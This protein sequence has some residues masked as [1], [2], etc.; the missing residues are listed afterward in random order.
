M[1]R[2]ND[3]GYALVFALVVLLFLSIVA[4]FMMQLTGRDL[5]AQIA[6]VDRM[7]AQ[8]SAQG[9]LEKIIAQIEKSSTIDQLNTLC[10]GINSRYDVNGG[11]NTQQTPVS[12]AVEYQMT[13]HMDIPEG[14]YIV[15]IDCVLRVYE[16]SHTG[17]YET[18]YNSYSIS[19]AENPDYSPEETENGGGL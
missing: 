11:N 6:S 9:E 10:N 5:N 14:K 19:T 8:Y 13:I 4:M 1:K 15:T 7:K 12:D 3:E 17:T 18:D 2:K 16:N